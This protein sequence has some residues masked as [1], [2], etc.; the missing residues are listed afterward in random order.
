MNRCSCQIVVRDA[1]NRHRGSVELNQ[2]V[3]RT[4]RQESTSHI[5]QLARPSAVGATIGQTKPRSIARSGREN[6]CSRITHHRSSISIALAIRSMPAGHR[7]IRKLQRACR[8]SDEPC[9]LF[10]TRRWFRQWEPTDRLQSRG[11]M[12]LIFHNSTGKERTGRLHG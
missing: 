4:C 2:L 1:R 6:L 3:R 12:A 9:P 5:R 7:Q 10:Q 8:S 11:L